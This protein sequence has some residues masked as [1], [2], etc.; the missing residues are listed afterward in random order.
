MDGE[1][2][3]KVEQILKMKQMGQGH[4]THHFVKW[5]GYPT[6]DNSWEPE[7]NLNA[8]ELIAVTDAYILPYFSVSYMDLFSEGLVFKSLSL[9]MI[10]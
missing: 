7:K 9:D 1:E 10:R 8:D 6:S 4:K 2:E 5:K 3:F